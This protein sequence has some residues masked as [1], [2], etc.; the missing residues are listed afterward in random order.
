MEDTATT[1][2]KS[3][4]RSVSWD[5]MVKAHVYLHIDDY[6]SDEVEECWYSEE[7]TEDLHFEVRKIIEL[8]KTP[9]NDSTLLTNDS[10]EK[11][12][13]RGLELHIR[14]ASIV[15]LDKNKRKARSM[16]LQE[17]YFEFT[18]DG[19]EHDP[20]YWERKAEKDLELAQR[21][22]LAT[23][24]NKKAAHMRGVND[25]LVAKAICQDKECTP[26]AQRTSFG[27]ATMIQDPKAE[28]F[29]AMNDFFCLTAR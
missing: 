7:E 25:A 5:P 17:Q 6:T 9:P 22:E 28:L 26:S 2:P 19:E 10:D 27:D 13:A 4:S 8:H 24:D 23:F 16:V 12:C 29:L 3:N 20:S 18:D 11:Y 14:D 1:T 21:Y 15:K